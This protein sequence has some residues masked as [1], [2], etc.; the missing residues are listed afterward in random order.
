MKIAIF[1]GSF[2]PPHVG[3]EKIA[4]KVLKELD[5]NKLIVIPT[6]INPFK[7]K[8]LLKSE[9]RLELLKKLFNNISNIIVSDIETNNKAPSYSINTLKK[10]INI[11]KPTKIYFIIGTDNLEHLETWEGF[12]EINSC[13][14]FVQ[15]RRAGFLNKNYDKMIYLDLN[16]DIS[17]TE[18]RDNLNL[19]F[20]PKLIKEDI[21]I[22]FDKIKGKIN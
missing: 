5:I 8:T 14:T 4:I 7:T 2:D 11:Y 17:S 9:T 12:D 10:L 18:L 6:F 19:E 15:I 1:G 16:I 13:V 3:H 20:I 21:K 22:I